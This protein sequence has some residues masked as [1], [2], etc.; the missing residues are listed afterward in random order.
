MIRIGLLLEIGLLVLAY[1]TAVFAVALAI[2]DNS[3][4]DIAW[5][6]GFV[7]IAWYTLLTASDFQAPQ[8]IVTALVSVWGLRL[9]WHIFRRKRGR[10][11]D[12]RYRKWRESWGRLFLVRSYLQVFILQGL[13]MT[14]V[15]ASVIAVN[16]SDASGSLVFA[17]VGAL[18]WL[19]GFYFESRGDRE[20]LRFLADPANKGKLLTSGLWSYTRHPNYFGESAQWW[21]IFVIALGYPDGWLT[22]I[23]PLTITFLLLKVSGVPMLEK[24]FEELPDWDEYRRRTSKFIPWFPKG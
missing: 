14:A 22:V 20:L 16:G 13:L 18:V 12:F 17:A 5:G 11:E 21:G 19:F 8:L 24:S 7:L 10:G 6:P 23:S 4:M 3:I 2:R 1:V 9:A 15:A